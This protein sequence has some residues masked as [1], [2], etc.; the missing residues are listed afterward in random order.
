MT[1]KELKF[2][3]LICLF[4]VVE[5]QL[6]AVDNLVEGSENPDSTKFLKDEQRRYKSLKMSLNKL[7]KNY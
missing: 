1:E 7:I 2:A 4:G 6:E 3:D 5:H